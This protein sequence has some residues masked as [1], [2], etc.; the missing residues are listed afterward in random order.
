MRGAK[1]RPGYAA[2]TI[3]GSS[4]TFIDATAV[5][6]ALP[7]LQNGLN[8]SI[9]DVQWVIESYGLTL[10]A[11]I[12]LGGSLG[13]RLGRGEAGVDREVAQ[14]AAIGRPAHLG[15]AEMVVGQDGHPVSGSAPSGA[16]FVLRSS[17]FPVRFQRTTY[18]PVVTSSSG[19]RICMV[20]SSVLLGSVEL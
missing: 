13:D 15:V 18:H 1:R 19:T 2:A 11:L 17:G 8:A 16:S 6:V 9:T 12:L 10:S 14:T 4:L 3:I 20:A 5:N 7:A